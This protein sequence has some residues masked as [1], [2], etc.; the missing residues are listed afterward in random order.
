ML[1][2]VSLPVVSFLD[3][4]LTTYADHRTRNRA[5]GGRV[6]G[7]I[8][9]VQ[10]C[11]DELESLGLIRRVASQRGGWTPEQKEAAAQRAKAM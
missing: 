8:T 11:L 2:E 4:P 9:K 1:L 3:P 7:R 10:Q 6:C 5:Q